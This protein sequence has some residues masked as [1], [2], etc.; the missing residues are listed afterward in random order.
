MSL[1][2]TVTLVLALEPPVVGACQAQAFGNSVLAQHSS[3][4]SF[5]WVF[6]VLVLPCF[7]FPHSQTLLI[8]GSSRV[9]PPTIFQ[10]WSSGAGL[11][12]VAVRPWGSHIPHPALA[13]FWERRSL[14][15]EL[16][17]IH[18]TFPQLGSNASPQIMLPKVEMPFPCGNSV[19]LTCASHGVCVISKRL[20]NIKK[21][22][23]NVLQG[24]SIKVGTWLP[25]KEDERIGHLL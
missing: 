14:Q 25:S 9:N 13:G 8:A 10:V 22:A 4:S 7:P 17:E 16:G 18:S 21:E 3:A 6:P 2:S 11:L 23:K 24:L 12:P 1:A 20:C 5:Q 19:F 15:A